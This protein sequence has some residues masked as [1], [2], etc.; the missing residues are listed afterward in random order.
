[1]CYIALWCVYKLGEVFPAAAGA[2]SLICVTWHKLD[3]VFLAAVG[4]PFSAKTANPRVFGHVISLVRSSR[5]PQAV[6]SRQK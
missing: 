2:F 4:A 6:F 1:M 5:L 3:E